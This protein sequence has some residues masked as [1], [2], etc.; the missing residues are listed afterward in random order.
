MPRSLR[1]GKRIGTVN[2]DDESTSSLAMM[3]MGEELEKIDRPADG[4]C[5]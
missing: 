3:M 4:R 5:R 2:V 1:L